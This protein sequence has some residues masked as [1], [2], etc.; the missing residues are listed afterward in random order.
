MYTPL[1]ALPLALIFTGFGFEPGPESGAFSL[2]VLPEQMEDA[3]P[4]QMCVFALA[5]V[6]PF[7][8]AGRPPWPGLYKP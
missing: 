7:V 6:W 2:T 3:V 1:S 8:D 5:M 4:G